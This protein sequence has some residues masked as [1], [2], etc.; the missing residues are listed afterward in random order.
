MAARCAV[1]GN[2]ASELK[3]KM[4]SCAVCGNNAFAEE[5]AEDEDLTLRCECGNPAGEISGERFN[6]AVCGCVSLIKAKEER[7]LLKSIKMSA[8]QK[9]LGCGQSSEAEEKHLDANI[10]VQQKP[11]KSA[12]VHV[13]AAERTE[14]LE[15]GGEVSD[16]EKNV[17][18][19]LNP[20]S[21][22]KTAQTSSVA[23]ATPIAALKT[24]KFEPVKS[25]FEGVYIVPAP[26]DKKRAQYPDISFCLSAEEDVRFDTPLIKTHKI[27]GGCIYGD[28][29]DIKAAAF[30]ATP[31]YINA[32]SIKEAFGAFM[33]R[34][35]CA[36]FGM[37]IL[38]Y[39]LEEDIAFA[40]RLGCEFVELSFD[41][42]AGLEIPD[43]QTAIENAKSAVRRRAPGL[44]LIASNVV[45]SPKDIIAALCLGSDACSVSAGALFDKSEGELAAELEEYCRLCARAHISE[46][47][48]S[49]IVSD[50]Q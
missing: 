36:V 44:K 49:D 40:Y 1:C 32:G 34:Y 27:E 7:E 12:N 42:L 38:A 16:R 26:L 6:C 41:A 19:K 11:D 18:G 39:R 22:E 30:D 4:F 15:T 35:G 33:E 23:F 25:V 46:F 13:N 17:D 2:P 20:A 43:P 48:A 14:A 24:D 37:R 50:L 28:N 29:R 9:E 47:C 31:Y 10:K 3:G 21:A 45:S 8:G 5:S